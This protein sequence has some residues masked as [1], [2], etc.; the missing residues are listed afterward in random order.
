MHWLA[1]PRQYTVYLVHIKSI[2]KIANTNAIP[3]EIH[4]QSAVCF[5]CNPVI[6]KSIVTENKSNYHKLMVS[7]IQVCNLKISRFVV[8]FVG[9]EQILSFVNSVCQTTKNG[10]E[11][12]SINKIRIPFEMARFFELSWQASYNKLKAKIYAAINYI[13]KCTTY[14]ICIIACPYMGINI[15]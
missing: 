6:Q 2:N 14:T 15:R 8:D 4:L 10:V 3:F 11:N 5:A 12:C 7:T 13:Y 1:L 9:Y